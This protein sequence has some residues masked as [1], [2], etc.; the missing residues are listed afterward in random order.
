MG[1]NLL[2]KIIPSW[3]ELEDVD[4]LYLE[5]D[6][7]EKSDERAYRLIESGRQHRGTHGAKVIKS[8]IYVPRLLDTRMS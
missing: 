3:W 2:S 8:I 5:I 7:G 4:V 1:I 6:S